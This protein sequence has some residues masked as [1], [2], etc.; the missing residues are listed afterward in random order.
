MRF[1]MP[2]NYV[3][4]P[5]TDQE[6]GFAHLLLSGTMNDRQAAEA[7]G[8]NP[9][10]AAYTKS[11]P[12]VRE[13][14]DQHR[15]AVSEKLIDQEAEGLRRLNIGRD[16][17]L[18]R[19]WELASLHPE[20]TKGSITGQ[21][22]AVAMIA[23]IE[24]L[25]PDRRVSSAPGQFAAPAVKPQTYVS[26]WLRKR[27]DEATEP[28]ESVTAVEAQ[29]TTPPAPEPPGKPATD[30]PSVNED[31]VPTTEGDPFK[32]VSWAP[33]AIGPNLD[34]YNTTTSPLRLPL[35]PWKARF[36]RGR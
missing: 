9:T 35:A 31:H 5:I 30:A 22:K 23:T 3:T 7:V 20:A 10:T 1:T 18:A 25:L 14:M 16:Q 13:Y 11:K 28:A 15:A 26:E 8:L 6:I 21:V 17:I 19:L 27:Q 24:G 32:G 29:P 34:A 12:R 36:G 4:D 2:K 33:N